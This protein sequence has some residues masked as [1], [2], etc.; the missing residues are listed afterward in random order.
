MI[1]PQRFHHG[2]HV[3]V[4]VFGGFLE[5]AAADG[6]ERGG[7]VVVRRGFGG[8]GEGLAQKIFGYFL[9]SFAGE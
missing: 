8:F 9:G 1:F 7:D 2:L 5:G 3:R 6:F 4:A